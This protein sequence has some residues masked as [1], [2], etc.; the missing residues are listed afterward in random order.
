MLKQDLALFSRLYNLVKPEMAIW[1]SFSNS[2]INLGHPRYLKRASSEEG[3][4]QISS[5]ACQIAPASAP[6]NQLSMLPFLMELSSFKMLKPGTAQTFEDYFN[7]V[8]APYIARQL[9]TQS[10]EWTLYGTFTMK[11]R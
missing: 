2:R 10:R 9:E 8:F 3:R 6:Y 1:R 7:Y 11:T 4:K 5:N